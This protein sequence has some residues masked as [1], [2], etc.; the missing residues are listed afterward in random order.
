MNLIYNY[1]GDAMNYYE[2]L[3]VNEN[4]SKEEIKSAYKVQMKKWHPDINKSSDAVLMSTKINEAKEV[5]MDDI[6]RKDYDEYLKNKIE[7]NYNRYTQNKN[8]EKSKYDKNEDHSDKKVTKW[9]YLK[10]WLKY[11][12]EKPLKKLLGLI[13]VLLE[14]LLCWLIK[15]L[16]IIIAFTCNIGSYLIKQLF[17]YLSPLLGIFGVLLLVQILTNGIV[18]TFNENTS[19]LNVL[20]IIITLFIS[21]LLLPIFSNLILSAKTFDILYNKIDVN[22]FKKCVGYKE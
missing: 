10:D 12:N 20:L 15:I 16:L 21:S 13:G 8:Q 1:I 4:A 11:A 6:K 2:L 17:Y 5:L 9:Q 14:S 7:E 3:G 19:M 18:N 22:L